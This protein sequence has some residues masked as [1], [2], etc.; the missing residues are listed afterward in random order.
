[1][2]RKFHKAITRKLNLDKAALTSKLLSLRR[3]RHRNLYSTCIMN[4]LSCD[5]FLIFPHHLLTNRYILKNDE[6]FLYAVVQAILINLFFTRQWK[7]CKLTC[8]TN[9]A[10]ILIFNH[11]KFLPTF[12]FCSLL[13]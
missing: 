11:S 10:S 12:F 7:L 13:R 2:E 1:M 6:D 9:L 3:K 4:L 8:Q 5:S